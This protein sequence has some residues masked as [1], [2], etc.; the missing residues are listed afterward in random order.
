MSK[1]KNAP[2]RE[3]PSPFRVALDALNEKLGHNADLVSELI[4]RLE[5][6]TSKAPNGERVTVYREE[7]VSDLT[8]EVRGMTVSVDY[9]ANRLRDLL[10]NLEV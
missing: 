9:D 7:P 2:A 10:A 4:H 5:P 3:V 6:V 8:A 1:T